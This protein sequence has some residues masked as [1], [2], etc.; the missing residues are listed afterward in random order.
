LARNASLTVELDVPETKIMDRATMKFTFIVELYFKLMKY[1]MKPEKM[2][3]T[4]GKPFTWRKKWRKDW[5]NVLYCSERCKRNK[6]YR[7]LKLSS[8]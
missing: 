8:L 4:C 1:K 3:K 5:E 7:V 2:C 6:N